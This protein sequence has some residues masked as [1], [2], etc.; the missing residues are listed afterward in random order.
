MSTFCP[1]CANKVTTR[2]TLFNW[3]YIHIK[4]SESIQHPFNILLTNGKY[5]NITPLR[6]INIDQQ[7]FCYSTS[8]YGH[9]IHI[10]GSDVTRAEII[11]LIGKAK[12]KLIQLIQTEPIDGIQIGLTGHGGL[13]LEGFN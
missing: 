13:S 7:L 9:T 2:H 5:A 11:D 4:Q 6:Y 3:P 8:K 10:S 12:N 1:R